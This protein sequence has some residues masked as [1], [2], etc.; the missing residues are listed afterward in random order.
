MPSLDETE[1]LLYSAMRFFFTQTHPVL[2]FFMDVLHFCHLQLSLQF[3]A[4]Y[5]KVLSFPQLFL[6]FFHLDFKFINF[7]FIRVAFVC[8]LLLDRINKRLILFELI[9]ILI[10]FILALL[11]TLFEPIALLFTF[12]QLK[13]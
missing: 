1:R 2:I 5:N 4:F 12:H 3:F 13:F 9:S 11:F 8:G 10:C 6:K 7:G